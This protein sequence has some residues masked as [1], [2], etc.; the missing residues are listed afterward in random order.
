VEYFIYVYL[1]VVLV[2]CLVALAC[3]MATF[4]DLE[5]NVGGNVGWSSPWDLGFGGLIGFFV[6]EQAGNRPWRECG[7][8]LVRHRS[9]ASLNV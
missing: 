4:L 1:D 9:F 7:S 8:G 6:K 3:A 2:M 5:R